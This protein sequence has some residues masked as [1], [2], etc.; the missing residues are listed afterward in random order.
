MEIVP[1]RLLNLA[2]KQNDAKECVFNVSGDKLVSVK[3]K[4]NNEVVVG[5][6]IGDMTWALTFK[7][8]K[9]GA[10]YD[11]EIYPNNIADGKKHRISISRRG[12]VIEDD[13]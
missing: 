5:H 9:S 10:S 4:A 2:A 8:L 7:T 11:L 12:L 13:L 6:K 1:Y 3:A